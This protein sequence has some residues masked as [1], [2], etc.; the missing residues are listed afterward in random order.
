M[1]DAQVTLFP[2]LSC[3]HCIVLSTFYD[4][5]EYV[6]RSLTVRLMYSKLVNCTLTLIY[7]RRANGMRNDRNRCFRG[8]LTCSWVRN[9]VIHTVTS[10][11]TMQISKHHTR[12]RPLLLWAPIRLSPCR[13]WLSTVGSWCRGWSPEVWCR[14]TRTGRNI[15]MGLDQRQAT[16]T[17]GWDLT[18]S[19][20][21]CRWAASDSELRYENQIEPVMLICIKSCR[22]K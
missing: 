13:Y 18:R 6:V 16:T 11:L 3:V 5:V 4:F 14:S 20:V 17:T 8:P 7:W 15:V 21:S 12:R 1:F 22:L 2:F 9:W 19:T 10:K